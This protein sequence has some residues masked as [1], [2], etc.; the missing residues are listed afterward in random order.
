MNQSC[1]QVYYGDLHPESFYRFRVY[2]QNERGVGVPTGES[3]Q[4][5]VPGAFPKLNRSDSYRF[6]EALPAELFYTSPWF[7]IVAGLSLLLLL[8]LVVACL[9][10][11]GA[12][13][14]LH[15]T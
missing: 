10:V 3:V 13:P 1:S 9:C 5:Y 4:V 14:Q 2:A 7:A 15:V 12:I 8:V 11:T 6:P